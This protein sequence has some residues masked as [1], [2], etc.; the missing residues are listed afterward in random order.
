MQITGIILAGGKSKRIGTDKVSLKLDV[1]TLL[2]R[3]DDLIQ[4]LFS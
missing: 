4:Y 3:S 2:K 1:K